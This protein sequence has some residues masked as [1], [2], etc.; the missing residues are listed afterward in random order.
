MK[1]NTS[2]RLLTI[3]I[4]GIS[5]VLSGCFGRGEEDP[6]MSLHTRDARIAQN[7]QLSKMTGTV[8]NTI[9]GLTTNIS[10]N[11]DGT[12]I[13]ITTNGTTVSYGYAFEMNIS[14][15]G[16]VT[17][18]E[19]FTDPA[20][21]NTVVITSTKTSYWFWANDV[22]NKT[23]INLDLTGTFQPYPAYDI[24]RLA[25]N[26]MALL[27]DYTDNYQNI[28][29]VTGVTTSTNTTVNLN[30]EFEVILPNSKN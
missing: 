26:D 17:S 7:W 6:W 30:I 12:N 4:V 21:P 15:K 10:Y 22:K 27:L 18:K 2:A 14:D 28:D 16:T 23:T 13:F 19:T 9:G 3:I 11:Y 20:N 5:F 29:P 8:V 25:W 1:I 24:P